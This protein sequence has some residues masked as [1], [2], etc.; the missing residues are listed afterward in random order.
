MFCI[1]MPTV[2]LEL[3]VVL[4]DEDVVVPQWDNANAVSI[5]LAKRKTK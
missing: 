4:L 3:L 2:V 1:V 5:A